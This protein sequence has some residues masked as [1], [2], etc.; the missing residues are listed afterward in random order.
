MTEYYTGTEQECLDIDAAI[1]ANCNWTYKG[2]VNWANPRETTTP[3]IFAI[4]VP[5]EHGHGKNSKAVMVN[6]ISSAITNDIEFPNP[7]EV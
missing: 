7:E 2:T 4:V 3:G 5:P 6:G 1:T